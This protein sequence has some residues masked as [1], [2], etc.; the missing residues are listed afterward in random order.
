[1]PALSG[2]GVHA[3]LE[4]FERRDLLAKRLLIGALLGWAGGTL[5]TGCGQGEESDSSNHGVGGTSAGGS[6]GGYV[7][8]GGVQSTGGGPQTSGGAAGSGASVGVG[9][10][11]GTG[12]SAGSGAS[13]GTGGDVGSGSAGSGGGSGGTPDPV[14]DV[15]DPDEYELNLSVGGG[16]Q[17]Y[18]TSAQFAVFDAQDPAEVLNFMEAAHQCFV[19]DWCWRSTGLS[20]RSDDGPYYKLNIY[21]MQI[22]AG[23]YMGYDYGAGLAFLQVLPNLVG[24]PEV[25]VHE[26]G[27]AM[28]LSEY[29]WVDQTNTGLWWES[30]ANFVAESFLTS[31]HCAD[32]REEYGIQEG[33]SIIELGR[34]IG[35]SYW[36]ICNRD[37]NYE[38]WPFF[39]YLT[40]NPDNYPGL[41]KMVVPELFRNHLGNNETPLHVLERL[42]EPVSVQTILGR[43]WARMAYVDIGS[44]AAQDKFF[45]GRNGIDYDGLSSVGQN[46]YEVKSDRRPRYGGAN[47]IPL[48]VTGGT[49]GV[50][51]TNLGNGIADSNFT[52]TLAVLGADRSVRYV[53]LPGGIGETAVQSGEEV[54]LVVVNTPDSLYMYDPA[55]FG[56]A[57]TSDPANTGLK[58]RVVINGATP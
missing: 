25:T 1:M 44:P 14:C 47:I 30:I 53:D 19:R 42:S 27:H 39:T 56:G 28:T 35:T 26:F 13:A 12:A 10:S 54:S 8:T 46:T 32:A 29:G 57:E 22:D 58:Y 52:A 33:D 36:T 6:G 55:D 16:G 15:Q 21:G 41:G 34:V 5:L 11:V 38:A 4:A 3:G 23:G 49:V 51:V 50:T 40:E 43:Y 24:V 2:A 45:K 31:R 9:G 18:E 37:N 20:H 48:N 17:N 7:G